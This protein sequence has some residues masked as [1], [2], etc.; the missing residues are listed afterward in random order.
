MCFRSAEITHSKHEN[1]NTT[2]TTN[3]KTTT[4]TTTSLFTNEKY[5]LT[6]NLIHWFTGNWVNI[7]SLPDNIA[8]LLDTSFGMS[9]YEY[10]NLNSLRSNYQNTK[11]KFPSVTIALPEV[12]SDRFIFYPRQLIRSHRHHHHHHHR[13]SNNHASNNIFNISDVHQLLHENMTNSNMTYIF[14]GSSH[15]RYLFDSVVEFVYDTDAI[16]S[17]DRHHTHA[18]FA[19]MRHYLS[20]TTE[21]L[22]HHIKQLCGLPHEFDPNYEKWEILPEVKNTTFTLI[23]QTGAWDLG[24]HELRHMIRYDKRG[25]LLVKTLRGILT[26]D[27]PCDLLKHV[28]F[29]TSVP[30]PLCFDDGDDDGK[31][32]SKYERCV[33]HRGHRVSGQISASIQYFIKSILSFQNEI[34]IKL[35]IIDAYSIIMP[36]ILLNDDNEVACLNHFICRVSSSYNINKV[37]DFGLSPS[38]VSVAIVKTIFSPGGSAILRSILAAIGF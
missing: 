2:F 21:E 25:P 34:Q 10:K 27:I 17:F 11:Y 33:T 24:M 7:Q 38:T 30:H 28:V 36:R 13:S 37:Q 29:V 9:V 1:A 5:V 20:Q 15:M 26:R 16:K 12:I 22:S 32:S 3:T 31:K 14:I 4:N 23:I 6:S 18:S 19:N 35:S 8:S